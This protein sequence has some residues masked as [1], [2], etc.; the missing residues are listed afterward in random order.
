MNNMKKLYFYF[1]CFLLV[2]TGVVGCGDNTDAWSEHI[3]TAD[4]I[5]EIARQDS[6]REAQRNTINANLILEYETEIIMLANGY[7]GS[8]VYIDTV[9][10]ADLF[11]ITT[12]QLAQGI[13]NMGTQKPYPNAPDISGFCIEWTTRADNMT[14]A[15]TNSYWGHWWDENGNTTSWGDNARVFAEYSAE[16]GLFHVGQMPG[17]LELGKEITFI[18][19]LKYQDKRVAI[20]ITAIPVERGE[21]AATVVNTQDLTL[22]VNPSS[23]YDASPLA[24]NYEQVL[25]DLGISSMDEVQ[26]IGVNADGSYAQEFTSDLGFWYDFEGFVGSW[27]D[28]ASVYVEYFGQGDAEPEDLG[29][30]YIGQMPNALEPGFTTSLKFGF[31]ANNKIVLLNINVNIL[32]YQDPETPP[33]GEPTTDTVVEITIEKTW[34]NTYSNVRYDVKEVLREA[35]KM[36]TYQIHQAKNSGELVVYCKEVAEEAPAYTSDVPG[37]WLN[38]KGDVVSWGAESIVFCCLGSSET[39]LYMYMG[40]H[41]ESSVPNSTVTTTYIITCN[42]GVVTMNLTLKLGDKAE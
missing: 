35:F 23:T 29:V 2:M 27:G 39:E 13:A 38:D 22:E 10:I 32:S 24:F 18:E 28:N 4:E 25:Q 15:N 36:T 40:N 20:V 17:M 16:D 11:G 12:T 31:L 34:D 7:D 30:V 21:V 9:K 42:G 37:Y 26:L 1:T 33:T 8:Y 41:P 5:A 19:C 3:L 14:N 6:I